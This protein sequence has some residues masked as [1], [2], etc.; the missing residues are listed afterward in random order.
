[1]SLFSSLGQ[2]NYNYNYTTTPTSG[3]DVARLYAYL[4]PFAILSIIGMWKMFTKAGRPGWAS[5]IPIYNLWVFFEI[6]GKPGWWA[7]LMVIPFVNIIG[8]VLYILAIIELSHRFGKSSAFA[9]LLF[10]LPF[11]GYLILG[12]GSATYN[13]GDDSFGG[14]SGGGNFPAGP[15]PTEPTSPTPPAPVV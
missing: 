4:A 5:L 7:I 2:V 10:F 3:A 8:L 14:N 11:I 1:M 15:T 6:A 12:F 13:G 9:L